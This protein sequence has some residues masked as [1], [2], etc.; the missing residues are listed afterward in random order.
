MLPSFDGSEAIGPR[1]ITPVR[2]GESWG[3]DVAAWSERNLG[4]TLFPWQRVA[5]EGQLSHRHGKLVHREALV[6]TARQNG[7][8]VALSALAGWW[9]TD[10]ARSFGPQSVV[11]TA[12]K[13]DRAVSVFRELAPVLEEKH[14][15][16]VTWSYGRNRVEL[17]DGSVWQVMAATPSNAHGSTNDLVIVDEVW[18]I[19]SDVIF[20]A[21]RPSMIARKN[22][23]LSM[24]S[25]AGDESSTV[26][27]QLREQAMQHIESGE[28]G[29]LFM[30]EW[31]PPP[32]MDYKNPEAWRWANPALGHT[33]STEAL[34]AASNTP[35][36]QAFLRAHA[37]VWVS[38]ASAWLPHG[39]WDSFIT[40]DPMPAGGYLAID[41]D[42]EDLRYVAVRAAPRADGTVQVQAE[43]VANS[44][45]DMWE[46]TAQ[47]LKDHSMRLLLTPGL[48][49]LCPPALTRR[50]QTVGQQEMYLWTLLVRNM[51]ME[52]RI[53]HPGQVNL[54]EHV[55]RAVSARSQNKTTLSSQKSPGPI[56]LARCMVWAVACASKPSSEVSKP[57]FGVSRT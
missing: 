33:I 11:T 41:T 57:A 30:A 12:H 15:G 7:K 43:F 39:L 44:M 5:L 23:M 8:T 3:A 53:K 37:N 17:P 4:V 42:L 20:D 32:G 26:M 55:G 1:L 27:L 34:L 6:S 54:S 19:S 50:M 28:Q 48:A 25:T 24:W 56:E 18:N 29:N 35:D 51:I 49:D 38:S 2:G 36:W 21:Y 10:H 52:G 45:P 47:M 9:L 46:R 22:P 14:G 40:D 16:K 31:S 13:L